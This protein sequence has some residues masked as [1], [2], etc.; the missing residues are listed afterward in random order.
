MA[1]D[2]RAEIGAVALDAER[3]GKREA[4]LAAGAMRDLGRRSD[5]RL[6]PRRIEE[7]ALEVEHLRTLDERAVEMLRPELDARAEVSV[8]GPLRVRCHQDESA[9]F[10]G[11]GTRAGH[12]RRAPTSVAA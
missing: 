8:H 4:D 6:R 12:P 10:R 11:T 5:R 7:V 3:I 2:Q 9:G 1:R